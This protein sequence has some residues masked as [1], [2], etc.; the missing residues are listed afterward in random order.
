MNEQ[1]VVS[2]LWA[3]VNGAVLRQANGYFDLRQAPENEDRRRLGLMKAT[4]HIANVAL[5]WEPL[6]YQ[7]VLRDIQVI[8]RKYFGDLIVFYWSR[9]FTK[10]EDLAA[11]EAESFK[12]LAEA[13]E[14]VAAAGF[15]ILP[16][17]R[18]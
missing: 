17:P 15:E 6:T 14:A 13:V 8:P 11:I 12:A 2:N 7:A 10:P 9:H 3:D 1:I 4:E 5:R 16:R 18:P